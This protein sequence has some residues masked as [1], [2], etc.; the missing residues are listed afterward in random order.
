M[1]APSTTPAASAA[2]PAHPPRVV[3][4]VLAR[5][6]AGPDEPRQPGLI[7]VLVAGRVVERRREL[8]AVLLVLGECAERDRVIHRVERPRVDRVVV[9]VAA[10]GRRAVVREP[11][12][13]GDREVD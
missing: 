9:R 6:V 3:V 13:V 4:I 11:T 7:R 5:L 10:G 12:A 2:V 1:S 8:V